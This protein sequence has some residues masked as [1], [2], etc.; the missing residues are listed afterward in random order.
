[1]T[2]D[3]ASSEAHTD[4]VW[5]SRHSASNQGRCSAANSRT[6]STVAAMPAGL[7]FGIVTVAIR[8][9]MTLA[10]QGP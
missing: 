6:A 2:G 8:S 1:M 7:S 3:H 4:T 9:R 5:A 10:V